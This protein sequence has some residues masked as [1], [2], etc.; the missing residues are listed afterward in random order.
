MNDRNLARGLFLIAVALAFGLTGFKYRL[1][2]FARPGPGLFPVLVSSLLLLSGVFTV[3]RSRLVARVR[4]NFNWKNITLIVG[5]LCAFS[6]VSLF[7]SMVAG[8]IALVFISTLAGSSYS[9]WRNAKI[10]AGLVLMALFLDHVLGLN[11]SLY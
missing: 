3:V 6:L 9:M 11:L 2:D 5:S 1:G 8:I 4:L 10:A 7:L